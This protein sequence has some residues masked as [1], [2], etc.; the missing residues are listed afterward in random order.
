MSYRQARWL[1]LLAGTA[2]VGLVAVVMY[3]RRVETVEV[4]AVL[5]FFPVFLAL[6]RWNVIGGG[7]AALAAAGAYVG[8]RWSAIQA[9]GA[10]HF[11]GL[12]AS[13]VLGLLAF[14]LVGGWANSQLR[15]SLTK[16]DLY[17]QIDDLTGLYNA[18]F[19]VQ[20]AEL[21]KA[22]AARYR[23]FFSV[24]FV[25]IPVAWFESVSRRQHARI[26]RELGR[27]LSES[28]RTVDRAVHSI[29]GDHHRLAVILP[30]T[31][32]TGGEVFAGKLAADVSAWLLA[33][34][35]AAGGP[36][37]AQVIAYPDDEEALHRLSTDFAAIDHVE[38]P[39]GRG[40]NNGITAGG[41]GP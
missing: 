29:D 6:L 26:F 31:G 1:V 8:M 24:A 16:L 32:K 36:I 35:V 21:E 28:I 7:L 15:A 5:L 39:A 11:T 4:V 34:G 14:G 22:R 9:V 3:L 17:D 18:R 37:R 41:S 19:F 20:E 27:M 2:I 23:T 25:D 38:H 10:G 40:V 30:E 33:D 12:I 13:R